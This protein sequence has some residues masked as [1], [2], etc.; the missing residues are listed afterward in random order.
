[1]GQAVAVVSRHPAVQAH[2][3]GDPKVTVLYSKYSQ[4]LYLTLV[5]PLSATSRPPGHRD[6]E[7][8]GSATAAR[9]VMSP[10]GWKFAT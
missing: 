3:H 4:Y 1:M 10:G 9:R 7:P 5:S 8:L 2:V 6:Q